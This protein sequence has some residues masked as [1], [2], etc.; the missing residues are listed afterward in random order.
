MVCKG[1]LAHGPYIHVGISMTD[2][3]FC[4]NLQGTTVTRV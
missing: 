1:A 4:L 3:D 2:D